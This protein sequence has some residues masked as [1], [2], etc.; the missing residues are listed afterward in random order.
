[1]KRAWIEGIAA[2][3]QEVFLAF[4]RRISVPFLKF[5]YFRAGGDMNLAE[6]VFQEALTRLVKGRDA[7]QDKSGVVDGLSNAEE[8]WPG[9]PPEAGESRCGLT[10]LEL[11]PRAGASSPDPDATFTPS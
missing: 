2:G 4:H 3:R 9:T 8:S 5:I 7:L 11:L 10:G 6:E 1:V